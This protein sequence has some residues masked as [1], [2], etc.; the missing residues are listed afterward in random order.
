VKYLKRLAL[1]VVM[2]AEQLVSKQASLP[3]PLEEDFEEAA[4]K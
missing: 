2:Y 1:H 3:R 4:F